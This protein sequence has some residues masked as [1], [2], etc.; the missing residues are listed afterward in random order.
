[1]GEVGGTDLKEGEALPL[2]PSPP[3]CPMGWNGRED[4]QTMDQGH[5]GLTQRRAG[6][7][8]RLGVSGPTREGKEKEVGERENASHKKVW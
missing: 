4:G 6:T 8:R 2:C 1:M 3:G 7:I 5:M